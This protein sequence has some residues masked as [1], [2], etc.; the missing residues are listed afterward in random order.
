MQHISQR[1]VESVKNILDI[2]AYTVLMTKKTVLT[3]HSQSWTNYKDTRT[4]SSRHLKKLTCKG[5]DF[6]AGVY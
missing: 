6:T 3:A 1:T 2:P 4:K 5:R